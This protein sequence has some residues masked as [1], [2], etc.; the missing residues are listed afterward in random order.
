MRIVLF[1]VGSGLSDFLSV[2]PENVEI[3]GLAD[4]DAKKQGTTAFGH[5][6]HN[7]DA[8]GNEIPFVLSLRRVLESSDGEDWIP[9]FQTR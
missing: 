6:V 8:K 7:P 1:G 9:C 5:R 3:V 4:N 2:V